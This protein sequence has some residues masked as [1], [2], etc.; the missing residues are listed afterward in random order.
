[1][2]A[3][4]LAPALVGVSASADTGGSGGGDG[5]SGGGSSS[6][7]E[8]VYLDVYDH[9][10][11]EVDPIT[12]QRPAGQGW[13]QDSIDFFVNRADTRLSTAP[14]QTGTGNNGHGS[15]R[16]EGFSN[17]HKFGNGM[18]LVQMINHQCTQA[19]NEAVGRNPQA[20]SARVVSLQFS[21]SVEGGN[22]GNIFNPDW[23]YIITPSFV[24]YP[25][26]RDTLD[27]VGS[28]YTSKKIG[29]WTDE[30]GDLVAD[31]DGDGNYTNG[32]YI[33]AAELDP[34]EQPT[35]AIRAELDRSVE[36][37]WD[38]A[39]P[40]THNSSARMVSCVAMNDREPEGLIPNPVIDV[41]K[42]AEDIDGAF[43]RETLAAPGSQN[44]S[45][46]FS[47]TGD[48]NLK[49]L[50]FADNTT[51]GNAVKW[52]SVTLPNGS[53]VAVGGAG[54]PADVQAALSG[55]VLNAGDP[56]TQT[57]GGSVTVNGTVQV[58]AGVLHSDEV[59]VTGKGVISGQIVTD[60]DGTE[61]FAPEPE[62][63]VGSIGDFVWEDTNK[64]GIQDAGEPGVGNVTV[65][66]RDEE[67]AV[68]A[69]TTTAADG[70]YHFNEVACGTYSVRFTAPSGYQGFTDPYQGDHDGLDSDADKDTG[71]TGSVTIDSEHPNNNTLDAGLVKEEIVEPVCIGSIGDFVWE[72]SN[73]NGV[74]DAG[75]PGVGNVTVKLLDAEGAVV[76]TTT[77]AADGSYHFNEVACGTYSVQFVAPEG[78][79]GFTDPNQGV[80]DSAD[81]DANKETGKT[82]P[83]TIDS[84]HPNNNTLD[85]GLVKTQQV[86]PPVV[87]PE[88]PS[89]VLPPS[90]IP[91]KLPS[92]GSEVSPI[93]GLL[94]V[95]LVAAGGGL[96]ILR[97]RNQLN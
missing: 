65:E 64:D 5:G 32:E 94:G 25:H 38:A 78:Y 26:W 73:K 81:S 90:R 24:H 61:Y 4:A 56:D 3:M 67:G 28:T 96:L 30:K 89:Q 47:N 12:G 42:N 10:S 70:S 72:D 1:M 53:T 14:R 13:G 45:V 19:I 33:N 59:T 60:K 40:N 80:D 71:V 18:T 63:C 23:Y 29:T 52:T 92:T 85:A 83:V 97:R 16:W 62:I 15:G 41:S 36:M 48:E 27:E 7:R 86:E 93:V 54:T 49:D 58:D 6:G 2:M 22:M 50:T 79:Q 31:S 82:A 95:L 17:S 21:F 9:V 20:T 68:V 43:E 84:E 51:S 8:K 66:L 69:T 77:T 35:A 39:Q 44:V 11:V 57:P 37:A 75:E 34:S 76:A 55:V 74:Q 46:T 88:I 87:T 91:N